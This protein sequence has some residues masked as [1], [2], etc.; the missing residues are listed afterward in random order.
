MD[1]CNEA[2]AMMN[3]TYPWVYLWL[4]Y[5]LNVVYTRVYLRGS[6]IVQCR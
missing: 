5:R 2:P 3:I 4:T 6:H 1:G